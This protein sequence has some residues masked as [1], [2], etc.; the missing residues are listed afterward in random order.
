MKITV[1]K[2]IYGY[3]CETF[4]KGCR[5]GQAYKDVPLEQ[6]KNDFSQMVYQMANGKIL[7]VLSGKY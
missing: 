4:Y 6:A 1:T 5:Y 7:Q 3:Y 2:N